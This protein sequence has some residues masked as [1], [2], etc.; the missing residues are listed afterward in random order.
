MKELK[1]RERVLKALSHEEPDRV[2]IDLGGFVSNICIIAYQKL[3]LALGLAPT[4]TISN[5]VQGAVFVEEEVARKLSIDTRHVI[6]NPAESYDAAWH[7]DNSFADEWGVRWRQPP[8]SYYYDMIENPLG[9]ATLDDIDKFPWPDL[10]MK[11]RTDGIKEKARQY[12]EDGFAVFTFCPGVFENATYIRGMANLFM[13]IAERSEFLDA[14]LDRMTDAIVNINNHVL[15]KIGKHIDGVTI[16]SDYGEQKGD[17]IHPDAWR[18]VFKKRERRVI[19][20]IKNNCEGKVVFHTCGSA[21]SLI[22]DLIEI[23]VDVLNPVQT[24]AVNMDP[25]VL[26]REYGE[27]IAFWGGAESQKIMPSGSVEDVRAEARRIIKALAPGG[28]LLFGNCHNIQND[29]PARNVLA[30][31]DEALKVGRYPIKL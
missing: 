17:L 31:F 10:D 30:L 1:P 7:E 27:R 18:E 28:G 5:M 9:Q 21:Y 26:K 25:F 14:F 11:G 22:S 13:D 4:Y 12:Q 8:S 6:P 16:F 24:S 29:V 15:G 2:P 23:G 20:S 3:K 19:E